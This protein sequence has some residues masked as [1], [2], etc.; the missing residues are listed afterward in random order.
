MG[1]AAGTKWDE[2]PLIAIGFLLVMVLSLRF[3]P[4]LDALLLGDERAR[5]LGISVTFI[6]V[7]IYL[8]TALLTGLAV[9]IAGIVGFVG[10]VVP[11]MARLLIGA[12]HKSL[13]PLAALFGA[14]V[15][16]SVDL[17]SRTLLSPQELPLGVL[18]ALFAAPP[19]VVIL[20]R[21][22]HGL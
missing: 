21:A 16:T 8:A 3:S 1:S 20:R 2:I 15:L 11:H 13:L 22:R 9:A 19:F 7:S 14:G 18:L 10:L 6:R 5:A 17:L 4:Q 12:R